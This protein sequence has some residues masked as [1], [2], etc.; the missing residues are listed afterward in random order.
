M[1]Y[2]ISQFS[3]VEVNATFYHTFKDQAYEDYAPANPIK[4]LELFNEP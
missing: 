4:L 2:D 3:A 1:D